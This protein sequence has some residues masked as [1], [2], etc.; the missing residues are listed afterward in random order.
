LGYTGVNKENYMAQIRNDKNASMFYPNSFFVHN[1]FI[2]ILLPLLTSD[3]SKILWYAIRKIIG[4]HKPYD[5]DC[6][7]ISQFRNG[8]GLSTPTVIKCLDA[9]DQYGI[10]IRLEKESTLLG[11][12]YGLVMQRSFIDINGLIQRKNSKRELYV[13]RAQRIESASK[14]DL[15]AVNG[16]ETQNSNLRSF[17]IEAKTQEKKQETLHENPGFEL[18]PNADPQRFEVS[19]EW[20]PWT[21]QALA[22]LEKENGISIRRSAE[23]ALRKK[24][25]VD[26]LTKNGV[27]TPMGLCG[28]EGRA[29]ALFERVVSD[30]NIQKS[31]LRAK[32][33]EWDIMSNGKEVKNPKAAKAMEAYFIREDTKEF[34]VDYSRFPPDLVEHI[35]VFIDK[36]G[37]HPE[38]DEEFERWT[39]SASQWREAELS[40]SD[41]TE[42]LNDFNMAKMKVL[43][44][45]SILKRAKELKS[46]REKR[47]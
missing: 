42:T 3:E 43:S 45:F 35:K 1:D 12:M 41:I 46:M 27:P 33:S 44:P 23:V 13:K 19:H 6:I 36:T 38:T 9:L 28:E 10:L 37:K 14:C 18:P 39:I 17:N 2:D 26:E 8:T 32:T 25:I 30:N 4:W 31:V 11:T 22:I 20:Q 16:I 29:L 15:L 47:G 34:H 24:V 21:E 5:K 40:V 7:P